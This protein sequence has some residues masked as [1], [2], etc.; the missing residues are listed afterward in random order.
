M[1]RVGL[2]GNAYFLNAVAVTPSAFKLD[3]LASKQPHTP[4]WPIM[5]DLAVLAKVEAEHGGP[6][7]PTAQ[8]KKCRLGDPD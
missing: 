4:H 2:I 6:V 7:Q 3:S 5:N 1:G 8:E